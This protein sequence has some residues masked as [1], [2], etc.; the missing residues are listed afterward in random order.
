MEL[1]EG[2]HRRWA[3]VAAPLALFVF[4][5]AVR[6]LPF[7]SVLIDGRPLFF[8]ADVYYHMRR[9]VYSIVHFPA[10]LGFDPYINFPDGGRAIWTP[11]FDWAIA[12]SLR[13]LWG[14]LTPT[15]LERIAIWVPPLLGA[16]TVV[17][18]YFLARRHFGSAVASI[19]G[20]VLAV[21]SA[22]FWYSQVG[23]I[24]HHAAVALATTLVLAAA[25][26]LLDRSSR[27][28][29]GLRP[30]L[31]SAVATGGA[32][33]AALLLWPGCLLHVGLV[34]TG[35]L[36]FL[37]RCSRRED[38][39]GFARRLALLHG[40]AF[41][42]VFP[43][44]FASTSSQWSRTSPV[45]LSAFQPWFFGAAALFS[46][47][48]AA[49]WRT[50]RAGGT[51]ARRVISALAIGALLLAFSAWLLPGLVSGMRDAWD[52]F[53][54]RDSFQAQVSES[55][56]LFFAGDQFTL[57]MAFTRLSIFVLLVPVALCVAYG[58][59]RRDRHRAPVLL[60]LWWTLGLS[61]VTVFQK[62]FFNSASVGI[63]LLLAL[64]VCW[65]YGKLPSW[66]LRRPWKRRLAKGA[67]A[68]ATAILLLPVL[69]SYWPYVANQIGRLRDR[70]LLV[71]PTLRR[72]LAV[73]E[74]ANWLRAHTPETSGWLDPTVRPE[75]G[76]LAPWTIG[77][78]LE[79]EARRPT[80]TD[81]FGD[82][83]GR[84]NY[85]LAR[86]YYQS[87]E[88]AA[89]DLLDRLGVR[90]VVS[91]VA[92]NYLG[93]DPVPGSMFF[94]LFRCDGSAFD[95]SPEEADR[96]ALPALERHRMIYES[97]PLIHSTPP[98]DSLFK[99]FEYVVGARVVGRAPP[100]AK[101]RATLPVRTNR[102]REFSYTAH[103]VASGDGTYEFRLPYANSGGPR[104][105]RVG[106]HYTLECG[107]RTAQVSVDE[108]AVMTGA[109]IEGPD[110]CPAP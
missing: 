75:Y 24:D 17:A 39:D 50:P 53:A 44:G 98:S 43:F 34:E 71:H 52:W 88:G 12:A 23:F 73:V 19:A 59:I 2:A 84:K 85:L 64:S 9:I 74:M 81:N 99:V 29:A 4:A 108:V 63:S 26:A 79:Y 82:D 41:L 77:H 5:F 22:H 42:L 8:G 68:F 62:R 31:R 15:Q 103:A 57:G 91:Q 40:V 48:C 66:L 35:L 38:A 94:S 102:H 49:C 69:W 65:V 56:P 78:V 14:P 70:P 6:A 36:L 20:A 13:P 83:V 1:V 51:Q 7:Q 60:L 61:V 104:A 10:A 25:M 47:A 27:E 30:G 32:I 28:P 33:G 86:R 106:R 76:I 110:L 93:E 107:A 97:P 21:L 18:L 101:L 67:L 45:V 11:F 95:P 100:G 55:S 92:P 89:A 46:A 3:R 72:Q 96:P 90:Y 37:L 87:E 58:A 109:R 80:V 16:A 54:K 105:V